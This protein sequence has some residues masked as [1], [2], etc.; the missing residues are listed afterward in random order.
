MDDVDVIV[1]AWNRERPDLDVQPPFADPVL[2]TRFHPD[3]SPVRR[4]SPAER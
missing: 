1:E 2:L 4:W 3:N